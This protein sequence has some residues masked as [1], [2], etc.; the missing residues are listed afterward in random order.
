[1]FDRDACHDLP[2]ALAR[3]WLETDGLSGYAS[4]TS[5]FCPTRRQHGLLVAPCGDPPRRHVFLQR[6]EETLHVGDRAFPLSLARYPGLFAPHGHATLER[7]T[8][9]PWPESLHRVGDVTITREVLMAR[10]TR[11][12]FV[13]YRVAGAP[14]P[15]RLD[16]RPLLPCRGADDLTHENAAL[17][18]RSD[19]R[20]ARVRWRP[21]PELPA[22]VATVGGVPWTFAAAPVWYRRVE[23]RVDLARGYEGHEDTFN[24]GVLTLTLAP[25]AAA[26]VAVGL[27]A[28]LDDPA[29]RFERTARARRAAWTASGDGFRGL[30]A[31]GADHYLAHVA[32]ERPSVLAGY[33]W[34]TEWGR[35]TFLAVPG[36]CFARGRVEAG[37]D[38]LAAWTRLLDGGLFPNRFDAAGRP[39]RNSVD[40]P[41]WF[42]LAVRRYDE[43]G[44]DATRLRRVFLPALRAIVAAFAAGTP[45]G[46]EDDGGLIALPAPPGNV[47]WMDAQVDGR[48]VTPRARRPVEVAALWVVARRLLADLEARFGTPAAAAHAAGLA[49][50]SDATFLARMWLP[51]ARR[52]ADGSD[53][54]PAGDRPDEIRRP[55]ALIA[56]ARPEVPLTVAQRR[57]V[58]RAADADLLTPWGLRSLAPDDVAYHPRYEGG[59]TERDRAY[60]QGAVWP[61]WLGAYVE[62]SLLA[63]GRGRAV[64]ARLR[65][66]LDGLAPVAA[67]YGLGHLPEVFDGDPPHRPGGTF[68]QAIGDAEVL[69]AYAL[70]DGPAAGR[71]G[72]RRR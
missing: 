66:R 35:D 5:L 68:A 40:A 22:V 8:A 12:V 36:L 55:N 46:G 25:G 4:L 65:A 38:I 51:A 11:G 6:F 57:D 47:T 24:P 59:P 72:R 10:G 14:G 41:L 69:R 39:E 1:V 42:A 3:E 33:P 30:L 56:A 71:A 27:D 19:A 34:F 37:G 31:Y 48:P 54:G 9:I 45:V 53:D 67:A 28:P 17:H 70:L 18:P 32:P 44:G 20:P 64:V 43:A 49:A 16:L 2:A 63:Y 58:V 23:Y 26:V 29:G 60:H 13:R 15:V 61:W 50:R 52:L 7:F 21:Y 62:A